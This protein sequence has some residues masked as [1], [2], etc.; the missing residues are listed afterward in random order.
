MRPECNDLTDTRAKNKC[1]QASPHRPPFPGP[2]RVGR[3]VRAQRIPG[4]RA[5]GQKPRAGAKAKRKRKRSS[6]ALVQHEAGQV[7]RSRR[8]AAAAAA[9]AEAGGGVAPGAAARCAAPARS[10][11]W[12]GSDRA[13]GAGAGGAGAAGKQPGA[14]ASLA[15][16]CRRARGLRQGGDGTPVEREFRRM[17]RVGLAIEQLE[18]GTG[19]GGARAA[20]RAGALALSALVAAARGRAASARAVAATDADDVVGCHCLNGAEAAVRAAVP[21][22]AAGVEAWAR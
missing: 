19:S 16:D 11:A 8:A 22:A 20:G 6:E 18:A 13:A 3:E 15:A 5:A 2:T 10:G 17:P 14:S 12:R 7:A 4:F 9:P 1:V 21:G